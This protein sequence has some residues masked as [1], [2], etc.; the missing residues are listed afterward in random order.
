MHSIKDKSLDRI[1][2]LL[3]QKE[4]KKA[5]AL[6]KEKHF[7]NW[8]NSIFITFWYY[9]FQEPTRS[10]LENMSEI[11]N[12]LWKAKTEGNLSLEHRIN[13]GKQLA[14]ENH[15]EYTSRQ[16]NQLEYMCSMNN[17]REIPTDQGLNE[18]ESKLKLYE[19]EVDYN[20]KEEYNSEFN[21]K[22]KTPKQRSHLLTLWWKSLQTSKEISSDN[23]NEKLTSFHTDNVEALRKKVKHNSELKERLPYVFFTKV[24]NRDFE[25]LLEYQYVFQYIIQDK[26]GNPARDNKKNRVGGMDYMENIYRTADDIIQELLFSL[27]D[28][29]YLEIKFHL[30]LLVQMNFSYVQ[31][32]E[33]VQRIRQIFTNNISSIWLKCSNPLKIIALGIERVKLVQ[34]NSSGLDFMCLNVIQEL[35]IL[36]V[37]FE[38]SLG[39]N[40]A[41]MSEICLDKDLLGR[42]T[43]IIL[44]ELGEQALLNNSLI[45][46][47]THNM[48]H[49]SYANTRNLGMMSTLYQVI[50]QRKILFNYLGVTRIVKPRPYLFTREV[51]IQSPMAR[52]ISK[53][54]FEII[55]LFGMAYVFMHATNLYLKAQKN[56]KPIGK[57]YNWLILAQILLMLQY[58]SLVQFYFDIIACN[59]QHIPLYYFQSDLFF[60]ILKIVLISIASYLFFFTP[61]QSLDWLN[62]EG[63]YYLLSIGILIVY[64]IFLF[65]MRI[66]YI[67]SIGFILLSLKYTLKDIL[68]YGFL[69][70]L[71]LV[72]FSL[73][74]SLIYYDSKLYQ[75]FVTTVAT[76]FYSTI[77]MDSD[78]FQFG[79]NT[80][81]TQTTIG[82]CIVAAFFI[83]D[84]LIISNL[85]IALLTDS[86]ELAKSDKD[87][88]F[89]QEMLKIIPKYEKSK[90]FSSVVRTPFPLSVVLFPLFLALNI[91]PKGSRIRLNSFILHIEYIFVYIAITTIFLLCEL[92]LLPFVYLLEGLYIF[93]E[94]SVRPRQNETKLGQVLKI[95]LRLLGW[96][97]IG[98]FMLLYYILKDL[99]QLSRSLYMKKRI[100]YDIMNP[101]KNDQKLNIS[102]VR[103]ISFVAHKKMFEIFNR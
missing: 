102:N 21:E 35:V 68:K 90:Q 87:I 18:I 3:N 72:A 60:E 67:K 54:I 79:P 96:Y 85:I 26:L 99:V 78:L 5:R 65:I 43:I 24:Q 66:R 91:L 36:G 6:I 9:I 2:K 20:N 53:L 93:Q 56:E 100:I 45:L 88:L 15:L 74:L 58:Y 48:W 57:A 13:N 86:Y 89:I 64:M 23:I 61:S 14:D 50:D 49:A 103:S 46:S 59:R 31:S 27:E 84:I 44:G 73:I 92:I 34:R 7:T 12:L 98:I 94:F 80:S 101:N 19:Q 62:N 40:I 76:L 69:Y 1:F 33:L 82:H 97:V 16:L 28:I 11:K 41:E 30:I 63:Y 42:R 83:C 71:Q 52:Y 22:P 25:Y 70:V 8:E 39:E 29:E 77:G 4:F 81:G 47:I 75:N 95:L 55:F 51:W 38:D 17:N 10:E 37:K 32:R